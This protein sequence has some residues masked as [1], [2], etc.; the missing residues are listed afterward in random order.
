MF[1]IKLNIAI[2][3]DDAKLYGKGNGTEDYENIKKDLLE[4][5][6]YFNEW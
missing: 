6:N 3:A 2:Y 1:A 5:D 4:L